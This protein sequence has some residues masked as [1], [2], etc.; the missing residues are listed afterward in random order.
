MPEQLEAPDAV[1]SFLGQHTVTEIWPHADDPTKRSY[2]IRGIEG[3]LDHHP[4]QP[5]DIRFQHGTL[6][7]NGVNG[8]AM[9]SLIE[10]IIEELMQLTREETFAQSITL[11]RY[12]VVVSQLLVEY[13]DKI[14]GK[15]N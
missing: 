9:S 13:E 7:A 2:T 10:V 6:D 1:K 14:Y 4:I 12:L 11:A 5:C 3:P 15:G 8:I